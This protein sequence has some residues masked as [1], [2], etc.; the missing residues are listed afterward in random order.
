MDC[1]TEG[2]GAKRQKDRWISRGTLKKTQVFRIFC[3]YSLFIC[4]LVQK[5]TK[6]IRYIS[7]VLVFFPVLVH[8]TYDIFYIHYIKIILLY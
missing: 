4:L 8:T 3:K 2:E 6:T 5:T 1:G 7:Q